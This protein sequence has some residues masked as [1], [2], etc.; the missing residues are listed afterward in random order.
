MRSSCWRE[1]QCWMLFPIHLW[2]V[3]AFSH[4]VLVTSDFPLIV[5][6]FLLLNV[7]VFGH[8]SILWFWWFLGPLG[9]HFSFL[10]LSFV[11]WRDS[12]SCCYQAFS[13][14]NNARY[15]FDK[16]PQWRNSFVWTAGFDATLPQFPRINWWWV[17]QFLG[18]ELSDD[19]LL[20][21]YHEYVTRIRMWSEKLKMETLCKLS[22]ISVITHR[23]VHG[24]LSLFVV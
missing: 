6:V 18:L 7:Y 16:M 2:V 15:M 14:F 22:L 20:V 10:L 1:F 17:L 3:F 24:F 13:P 4:Q 21:Y 12:V 19:L 9:V 8:I 23:T 11:V 5:G